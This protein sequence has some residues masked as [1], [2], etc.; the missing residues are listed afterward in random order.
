MSSWRQ[1]RPRRWDFLSVTGNTLFY[2]SHSELPPLEH[3]WIYTSVV[4]IPS[5]SRVKG[6][7]QLLWGC[8]WER[9]LR[10]SLA[11]SPDAATIPRPTTE[12]PGAVFTTTGRTD[13][14]LEEDEVE[15]D[16]EEDEREGKMGNELKAQSSSSPSRIEGS[17]GGT[18]VHGCQPG[19]T[20][21]DFWRTGLRSSAWLQE[22]E[23]PLWLRY[24]EDDLFEGP[25]KSWI[26]MSI[27]LIH[28][29]ISSGESVW[30]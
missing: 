15:D 8:G 1:R 20:E 4:R 28:S 18:G 6:K 10:R 24:R 21:R 23:D 12:G 14:E 25:L 5:S 7:L 29:R 27:S 3:S 22:P 9:C 2:Q 19:A 16:V 17:P 13:K 11:T 26:F 30:M